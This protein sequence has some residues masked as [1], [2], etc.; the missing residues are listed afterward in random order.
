MRVD[1]KSDK[2]LWIYL[3]SANP[4]N[5][6][7][8]HVSQVARSFLRSEDKDTCIQKTGST[9]FKLFEHT[10]IRTSQTKQ[11]HFDP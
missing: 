1:F 3:V 6:R 8:H 9:L 11:K 10:W 4:V 2:N 5:D 7:R